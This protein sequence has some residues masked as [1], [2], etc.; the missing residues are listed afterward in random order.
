MNALRRFSW[1]IWGL[2]NSSSRYGVNPGQKKKSLQNSSKPDY[3]PGK[4]VS[5]SA[6]GWQAILGHDPYVEA[7]ILGDMRYTDALVAVDQARS[8]SEPEQAAIPH[9]ALSWR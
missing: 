7:V 8:E 2:R 6:V 3:R 1:D 5:E 4:I 9:V